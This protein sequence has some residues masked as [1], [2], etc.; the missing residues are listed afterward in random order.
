MEYSK[1]CIIFE[2]TNKFKVMKRLSLIIVLTLFSVV[3]FGQGTKTDLPMDKIYPIKSDEIKNGFKITPAED[4]D[5]I[6]KITDTLVFGESIH[7][8]YKSSLDTKP[9]SVFIFNLKGGCYC[10]KVLQYY[11]NDDTNSVT[12]QI[13]G[14]K[15]NG[16][17][18]FIG[19]DF[20]KVCLPEDNHLITW[21]SHL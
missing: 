3:L 1:I 11:V 15:L 20:V 17:I 4:E 5:I 8:R 12:V 21:E 10:Y 2:S 16:H 19:H 13:Q 6:E 7:L 18:K 14:Q 9:D